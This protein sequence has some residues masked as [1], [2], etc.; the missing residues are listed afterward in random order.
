VAALLPPDDPRSY[1][2]NLY[3]A[4]T[5]ARMSAKWEGTKKDVDQVVL[6]KT[7]P[8]Y[9]D[10]TFAQWVDKAVTNAIIVTNN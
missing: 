4:Y 3:V 7:T 10:P 2:T 1:R 9:K 5:L 8:N 6:L